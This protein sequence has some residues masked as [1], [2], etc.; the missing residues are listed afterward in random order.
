MLWDALCS[1]GVD[2]DHLNDHYGIESLPEVGYADGDKAFGFL[3]MVEGGFAQIDTL[4]SNAKYGSIDRNNAI[5]DVVYHL[6]EAAK[7]LKVKGIVCY[8]EIPSI[9]SRAKELGFTKLNHQV[10]AISFDKKS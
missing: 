4:V 10:I 7:Q 3:R 2:K 8:T 6:L 9:I 1:Q 5:S